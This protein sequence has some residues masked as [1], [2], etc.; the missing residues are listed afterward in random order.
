CR[1]TSKKGHNS[2]TS[3]SASI[4]GESK[5]SSSRS[6]TDRKRMLQS[7]P[8]RRREI[9]QKKALQKTRSG[10]KMNMMKSRS[11]QAHRTAWSKTGT[12]LCY[13]TAGQS[14]APLEKDTA[15]RAC[16]CTHTP[17]TSPTHPSTAAKHL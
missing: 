3:G 2:T 15:P 4:R 10:T 6:A 9:S 17:S 14:N 8:K 7:K 16:Y 1:S 13:T 11:T 5:I 12:T